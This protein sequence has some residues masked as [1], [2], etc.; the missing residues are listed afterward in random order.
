MIRERLTHK[1][2]RCKVECV[3]PYIECV[4]DLKDSLVAATFS[5]GI[6]NK[7]PVVGQDTQ[8][9]ESSPGGQLVTCW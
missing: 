2:L 4:E 3:D 8:S 6:Q 9:V 7:F 1:A 5:Q